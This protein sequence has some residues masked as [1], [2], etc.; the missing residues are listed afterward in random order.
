MR[1]LIQNQGMLKNFPQAYTQYSEDKIFRITQSSQDGQAA[2][3]GKKA[4]L[5]EARHFCFRQ[6]GRPSKGLSKIL[7]QYC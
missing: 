5:Q 3:L 6:S 4:I 7:Q 2:R 1:I